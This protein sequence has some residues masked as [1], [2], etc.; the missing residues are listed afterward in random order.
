MRCVIKLQNF[1]ARHTVPATLACCIADR[2]SVGAAYHGL[3]AAF[4]IL[5][6]CPSSHAAAHEPGPPNRPTATAQGSSG[7]KTVIEI[8]T[9]PGVYLP[10][11]TLMIQVISAKPVTPQV[12]EFLQQT[13]ERTLLRNDPRLRI[14]STAADTSIVCTIIDFSLSPGVETRTRQEYQRTGFT[15]VTDPVTGVSRTEDQYSFVDV[16]Y[17]ALVL[18]ARMSVT[19]DVTDVATGILLHSDRFDVV[20]TDARDAGLGPGALSV[21]DQNSIYLKLADNAAGLIWAQLCPRVY[22]D[23]VVLPSGRLNDAGVLMGSGRWSEARTLLSAM[24]AF[25]NPRD[26]AY[27][28]YAIGLA[29]EALAYDSFDYLEKKL[30]LER[31]VGNYRRATELKP[32]EDIF[33]APKNRAELVLWQTTGLVDQVEVFREAKKKGSSSATSL[34]RT[35]A[36][37]TSLFHQVRSRMQP[38][39]LV[40][41]NQTVVQWVKSGR[42]SEYIIASIKHAAGTRFDLSEAEVLKLRRDGVNKDV[43]NAMAKSRRGYSYSSFGRGKALIFAASLLWWLPFVFGR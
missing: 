35:G 23:V 20:Y 6:S 40:I 8:R 15:T 30:H 1:N 38:G 25:K 33:W 19:C 13:L 22:S 37:N 9:S 24:P 29:D 4:L 32:T 16:P 21:D 17:R 10:G 12:P 27:R 43:L 11:P 18:E 31:A 2:V 42:S 41:N 14:A 28:L 39:M 3:L 36:G 7:R 34:D 5:T 26:D